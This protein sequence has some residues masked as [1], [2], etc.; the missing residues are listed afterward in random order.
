MLELQAI[1][2]KVSEKFNR[3]QTFSDTPPSARRTRMQH[4]QRRSLELLVSLGFHSVFLLEFVNG[5]F[6]LVQVSL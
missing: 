3:S 4:K 6:S 5:F 1:P 2:G